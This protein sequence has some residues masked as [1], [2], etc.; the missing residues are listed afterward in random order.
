[1]QY[2]ILVT[3]ANGYIGKKVVAE[4][5]KQGHHAIALDI[6]NDGIDPKAEYCNISLFNGATDIYDLVGRPDI[7]IHLAWQDG[8]QHNADSH[9]TN[10]SAHYVFIKNMLAGGLKHLVVMGTMHEIGYW[11][12]AIGED[13]PANPTSKYGIAK[14]CLRQATF[15]LIQEY[16]DI[17]L[18]WLRAY[19]ITGEDKKNQSIFAKLLKAEE[20]KQENFPFTSGKN[21]YDFIDV[22][23]LAHQIVSAAI[24]TEVTG[25]IECCT[26]NP[27][28]LAEKVE[29]FIQE[30]NMNIKLQYGAFP[31]RE[32][33]SPGV[34]GNPEKIN[35]ILNN[36]M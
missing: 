23:D 34:W 25:I 4:V 17:T 19:Y 26:G 24:Q 1:M 14:N 29:S 3:G 13:T 30:N 18:Q 5:I 35:Q 2:R 33:D 21:L 20:E 7:C 12:G 28:S 11:E 31:D 27:I 16:P 32:Y 9:I 10:L 15:K 22:Y 8:F 36:N 6:R